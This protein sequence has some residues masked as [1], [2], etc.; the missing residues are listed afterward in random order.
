MTTAI[1]GS[2]C[3]EAVQYRITSDITM[4]VNCH[5]NRCKK[6]GGGAFS[7]IA[8]VRE[9]HL[10]FTSGEERLT[11]Y[12][13]GDNVAKH[14]CSLCGTS[15]FNRNRRYPGRCM[16]ALGSLD[17]PAAIVPSVNVHCENQLRW[18]ILDGK[19]ENFEQDYSRSDVN[20][21]N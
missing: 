5:C 6:A 18:V 15:I 12:Q 2:C 17:N 20:S 8:V 1:T 10:E 21:S 9:K 3:C 19:M 16:V 7:S 4:A 11:T 13:L 14:F